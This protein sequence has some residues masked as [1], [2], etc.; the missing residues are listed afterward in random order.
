M[1]RFFLTNTEQLLYGGGTI[2]ASGS[3]APD[4]SGF[5]VPSVGNILPFWRVDRAEYNS[6]R[7]NKPSRLASVVET[8][9]LSNLA[10]PLKRKEAQNE[11]SK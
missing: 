4:S 9:Q 3:S 5:F 7:A 6:L 1:K 10:K 11:S 8:R 2:N